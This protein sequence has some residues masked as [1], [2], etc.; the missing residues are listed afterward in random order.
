MCLSS[1]LKLF[2]KGMGIAGLLHMSRP[3]VLPPYLEPRLRPVTLRPAFSE[4]FA[5]FKLDYIISHKSKNVKKYS[6]ELYI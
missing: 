1:R 3:A 2:D 6:G 4:R 5:L